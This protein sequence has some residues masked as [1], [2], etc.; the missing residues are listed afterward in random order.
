MVGINDSVGCLVGSCCFVLA[1]VLAVAVVCCGVVY[2]FGDGVGSNFDVR[3]LRWCVGGA[4]YCSVEV[5][6]SLNVTGWVV[7]M[8]F[9]FLPGLV[10]MMLVFFLLTRQWLGAF[11]SFCVG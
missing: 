10:C 4:W 3:T 11:V 5:G 2:C 9:C 7:V 8:A 6:I 1:S